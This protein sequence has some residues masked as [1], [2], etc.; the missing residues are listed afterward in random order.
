MRISLSLQ[1]AISMM[2]SFIEGLPTQ[3]R[4][5]SIAK[6]GNLPAE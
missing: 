4:K 5:V 3:Q 1:T 6:T 2:E